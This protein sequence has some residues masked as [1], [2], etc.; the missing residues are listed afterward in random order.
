MNCV[1]LI[2]LCMLAPQTY[3]AEVAANDMDDSQLVHELVD[4]SADKLDEQSVANEEND[5]TEDSMDDFAD[6]L[7]D[8]LADKLF[9]Q[10]VVLGAPLQGSDDLE[11]DDLEDDQD[12]SM[13]DQVLGLEGGAKAMKAMKAA[14]PMKAM[15]ASMAMKAM[16]AMAMKAMKKRAPSKIAM[17]KMAKYMVFKGSKA[18]TTG[19]LSK[20]DLVKNKAGDIVSKKMQLIGKKAYKNVKSWTD[21]TMAARKAL[22]LK[23]FVAIKKGSPLYTKAKSLYKPR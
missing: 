22:G 6:K 18:K 14:A 17:G 16:A 11:D 20:G 7:V 19:G 4:N 12:D 9:E 15:K 2:T 21:A 23:G 10:A 3:A 5:E 8:K 13:L 1:A